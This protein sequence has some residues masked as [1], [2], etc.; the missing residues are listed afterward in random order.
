MSGSVNKVILIGNLGRD[1]EVRTT[2]SGSKI[3]NLSVATSETWKD[4]AGQRQERVEWHRVV[5]WDEKL[6]EV[7]ERYLRKGSKVYMEGALQTK[8]WTAQDGTEKFSTDVVLQNFR[9]VLTLLDSR[10]SAGETARGRSDSRQTAP[11]FNDEI[12]F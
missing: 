10:E 7:A 8:K 11:A 1:P 4:R 5:I 2:S 12:P 3:A 9:G 6:V